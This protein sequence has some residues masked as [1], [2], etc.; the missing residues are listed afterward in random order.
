MDSKELKDFICE[1]LDENFGKDITVLDVQNLTVET[2]YFVICS[3]KSVRQ[4]SAL[5]DLIKDKCEDAGVKASHYDIQNGSKWAVVDFGDVIM[6]V[7]NDETRL[8]YSLE[9]LWG[10]GENVEKYE[11]KFKK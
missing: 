4:V 10:N 5:A 7:F 11:P 1:K 2:D 8:F 3:A 9:K 6:H